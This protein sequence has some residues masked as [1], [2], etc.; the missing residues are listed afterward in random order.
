MRQRKAAVTALPVQRTSVL[1]RMRF[2]LFS[3]LI[4]AICMAVL[5]SCAGSRHADLE[6]EFKPVQLHWSAAEGVDP[7][8]EYPG[9]DA[10]V[11]RLTGVIMS[12]PEVQASKVESLEYSVT[13][14]PDAKT[15]NAFVFVGKCLNS[16]ISGAPECRWDATCDGDG[17]IVVNFHNEL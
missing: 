14:A 16:A 8:A 2:H 11:I 5:S 13:I 17:K 1:A 6:S 3:I 7:D 10:C 4:T 15:P 9:K 12:A